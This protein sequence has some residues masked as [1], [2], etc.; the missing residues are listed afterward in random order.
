MAVLTDRLDLLLGD[1][2]AAVLAAQ[3]ELRTV[4]DLLR[5][6]PRTY[7]R[8]GRLQSA[9]QG[10]AAG[11]HPTTAHESARGGGAARK[12][13]AKTGAPFGGWKRW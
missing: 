10:A 2:P 9:E 3:F 12:D 5:H 4:G 6:Y 13:T 7:V 1:G 11:S 8:P